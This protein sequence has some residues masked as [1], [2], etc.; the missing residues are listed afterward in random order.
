MYLSSSRSNGWFKNWEINFNLGFVTDFGLNKE[1]LL[2]EVKADSN[3]FI[4]SGIGA[5]WH[6]EVVQNN[7]TTELF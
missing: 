1:T 7:E 6:Q 3:Y 2:S 4:R 5:S